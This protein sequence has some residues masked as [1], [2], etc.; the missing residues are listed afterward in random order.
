MKYFS[1]LTRV[2]PAGRRLLGAL[3]PFVTL[4][5]LLFAFGRGHGPMP[6]LSVFLDPWSGAWVQPDDDLTRTNARLLAGGGIAGL[7]APVTVHFDTNRIPHVFAANDEDLYA[8]Q[9]YLVAADRLWQMDFIARLAE[10]RLSEM[11]GRRTI[12]FDRM[13][14]KLG[15]PEAAAETERLM[16]QDDSTRLAMQAYVRGVNAYIESLN[17]R[18]LPFEY[19]LLAFRPERWTTRKIALLQKFMAYNLS[20]Y[21]NDLALSRSFTRVS[22]EDFT[23]LFPLDLPIPAPIIPNGTKWPFQALAPPPPAEIYHANIDHLVPYPTPNPSNGSNNWAVSGAKSVTGKPIV[24]NDIHLSYGLPTLWYEIQLVS[25]TQNVY[26][27][28]LPGAPGVLL[29]FNSKVAWAVTNA[30]ADVVDWF[31]MRFKDERR[32]EYSFDGQWRP[33]IS[34]DHEIK[35]KGEPTELLTLH[36]THF[37]PIVYDETE[38]SLNPTIP[39]GLALRWGALDPSNDLR[40]FL[41]LNRATDF[42]S[43]RAAI[44]SYSSPA[45][46]FI[47]A[48]SNGDI[49]IFHEGRLPVRWREQ[50]RMISDGSDPAYEW[51]GF[52]PRDELPISINPSRGF[53]SSANQP[54]TDGAYPHYLGWPFEVP[55]RGERVNEILESKSKFSPEDF[56]AMQS[57]VELIPARELSGIL[58]ERLPIEGLSEIQSRAR[59]QLLGWDHRMDADKVAP[60][61]FSA[62][63]EELQNRIW[64]DHFPSSRHFFVPRP[65]RTVRLILNEP[66]SKWFDRIETEE[67][68]TLDQLTRESFVHAVD[69]LRAKFGEKVESWIWGRYQPTEFPHMARI[70]GLGHSPLMTRGDR[71]AIFANRGDHGPVWKSVVAV[72]ETDQSWAIYPGGQSGHPASRFYDNFLQDW[73]DGKFRRLEYLM[74]PEQQPKKLLRTL[75]LEA[76]RKATIEVDAGGR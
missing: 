53:V 35:I 14:A 48:D 71:Y 41:A 23:E 6:A 28:S 44:E 9:G 73:S 69:G 51:H 17:D 32:H 26:G 64:S 66:D 8:A 49:G 11:F 25:P 40:T 16:L 42:A 68:E 61:I 75:T 13:F 38:V 27:A 47:C 18:D 39:R 34:R 31:E 62:W 22:A 12:E 3:W 19:K 60:T 63:F 52:V 46:N 50:G 56:L 33:I 65:H 59:A 24:S 2:A 7:E 43:C 1:L 21:S 58:L 55:Y 74:G 10:G 5:L 4:G 45:Q 36:R 57:D 54:P 72:G 37:G 67:R 15:I 30:G 20:F 29:G 70:P 76:P